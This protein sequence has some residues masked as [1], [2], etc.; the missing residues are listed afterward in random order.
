MNIII[1]NDYTKKINDKILLKIE[2][3]FDFIYS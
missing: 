1:L 2:W 3:E